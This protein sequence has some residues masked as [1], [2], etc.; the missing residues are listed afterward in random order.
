MPMIVDPAMR[1]P[2]MDLASIK[3]VDLSTLN[4]AELGALALASLEQEAVGVF[5]RAAPYYGGRDY[6]HGDHTMAILRLLIAAIA[7]LGRHER[8]SLRG[9]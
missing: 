5:T 2:T 1:Q 3:S 7:E 9:E 4:G 8:E 6:D